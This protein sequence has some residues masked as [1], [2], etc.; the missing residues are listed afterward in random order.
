MTTHQ[1]EANLT[2][3]KQGRIRVLE[4]KVKELE[5]LLEKA[6]AL[7]EALSGEFIAQVHFINTI[8]AIHNNP[9]LDE[10][11]RDTAVAELLNT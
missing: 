8:K 2:L 11:D 10:V 6:N 4:N 1:A 7:G 3:T 5:Q 9:D